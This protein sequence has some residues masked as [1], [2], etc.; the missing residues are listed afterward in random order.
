MKIIRNSD[1]YN[2]DKENVG[3]EIRQR[4]ELNA[5]EL[6][7]LR[8]A[9]FDNNYNFEAW[10]ALGSNVELG[11]FTH[12]FFRYFG[13]FPPVI[14]THLITEYTDE[15]DC[16]F[17]PMSGSG[18]TAVECLHLGRNVVINDVNPLSILLAKVKTTHIDKEILLEKLDYIVDS[19]RPLTIEDFNY[20]PVGLKNYRHWFLGE[21]CDSLRGLKKIIDEIEEPEIRN[22]FEACFCAT[23]R[24]VSLATTQQGRLFLDVKSA[25]EDALDTFIKKAKKNINSVDALPDGEPCILSQNIQT[26]DFS[27]YNS[28]FKLIILH[29]PYF[30]SYKYSSINSL[31][32]SWMNKNQADV[33]KDEIHEFFKVGKKENVDRYI[34]DMI[35]AINNVVPTL[36]TG[37]T[38]AIM[39]GDTVIKGEYVPVTNMLIEKIDKDVLNLEK[40]VLRVPKYTEASWA[41][42]QRRD[43]NNVGITLYDYIVI[44]KKVK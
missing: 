9:G 7:L 18:T 39:I 22:F 41:T 14:S 12:S 42:S 43:T 28:N 19:Y 36:A 29:P 37:G 34:D 2:I 26:A 11:Y 40:I 5:E 27:S 16:V 23:V 3:I 8:L 21:T 30:N 20:E 15:N 10:T 4:Y 31:E 17:D 1:Y 44:F 35:L 6:E 24:P 38:M 25:K 13:K 32:L 33:R